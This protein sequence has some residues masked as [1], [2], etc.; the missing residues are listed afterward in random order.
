MFRTL[1]LIFLIFVTQIVALSQKNYPTDIFIS[2]IDIP[3][4][5]SGTFGEL[6]SDHF[7]SGIDIKTGERTGLNV[8]AVAD[9]YISRI[10]VQS[11]GYGYALYLTHPNGYVSVYGH[12][13]KYNE[14]INQFVIEEQYKRQS[15]E[16]DMYLEEDQF[17]VNQGDIIALS[18]NSGYSGGPHLH[19]EIRDQGSQKPVNPLLFDF[20]LKDISSPVINVLKIYPA[21]SKSEINGKNSSAVYYPTNKGSKYEINSTDT[22][23]ISGTAYFGIN[24]YDPFYGGLNKNG[25]YS[26]KMYVDKILTYAHSLETFSFDETR[27]INSL[28]DYQEYKQNQR[29]VQKAFV[30]PNNKLSIYELAINNGLVDFK[31][32]QKHL[33]SFE[34]SDINNNRTSLSFWLKGTASHHKESS[35]NNKET[36][37]SINKT[38][39]FKTSNLVLQVPGNALY[40]SL[41]FYYDFQI[42]PRFPFAA[43]HQIHYD[44]VPLHSWCSLAIWPDS[45]PHWLQ[46]KSLIVKIQNDGVMEAAGGEWVD[47][48]IQTSIREFGNYTIMIDTVPPEIIPLNI[49][50]GKSLLAQTTLEVKILD[51]L[52]GIKKYTGKLNG[53]WIL[54]KYDLKSDLLTYD[55]DKYLLE[56]DN[57]FELM[58]TDNKNNITEYSI[59][60]TY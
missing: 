16:I 34:V 15:Y 14:R 39:T 18:G 25:V 8:Y 60:I 49:Y 53:H 26:I 13:K 35:K 47:G 17:R 46:D 31:K 29:R 1:Q 52:S 38:N 54:M 9:G 44:Y 12:L 27:Y 48:F 58:V 50:E 4:K 20:N 19:F 28:I 37:F 6:R 33:I 21:D 3:I 11:G 10:K 55:F 40:D 2:P 30:Q 5:L 59:N 22:I 23:E 43:I 42:D 24:C 41:S 36:I 7:H 51:E 32:G 45:I 56:G 57:Y